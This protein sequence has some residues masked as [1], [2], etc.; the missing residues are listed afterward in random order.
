M[1][2]IWILCFIITAPVFGQLEMSK[3]HFGRNA[4][5]DFV[6]GNPMSFN[7]GQVNSVES[8]SS[9]STAGGFLQFYTDGETVFN[10]NNEVMANGEGLFGNLS[11]T[12]GALIVPFPN[13][14]QRYYIFTGEA[15]QNFDPEEGIVRGINYSV[16]DMSASGGLGAVIEKNTNLLSE[17]S[18]KLSAVLHDNNTDYWLVTNF[19][20]K[21]Y[22]Y[23]VTAS[24]VGT[25]PTITTIGFNADTFEKIRGALTLSP[26][27]NKLAINHT[28]LNPTLSGISELYD[29]N[30]A[31]GEVSN[32]IE[33]GVDDIIY[34]GAAFSPNSEVLY[35]NGKEPLNGNTD[36]GDTSIYQFDLNAGDVL[37]SRYVVTR[38]LASPLVEFAGLMQVALDGKIYHSFGGVQLSVIR[39]P[40]RLRDDSKFQFQAL[41]LGLNSS[42]RSGLPIGVQSFYDNIID[43]DELCF[44]EATEFSLTTSR[45]INS[46]VWDFGDPASGASNSSILFSPTHIFSATGTYTIKATVVFDDGE[47]KQYQMPLSVIGS[48]PLLSGVITKCDVD[49]VDDGRSL[50]NLFE[51]LDGIIVQDE[52]AN[53]AAEVLFFTSLADAQIEINPIEDPAS[54][55]NENDGQVVYVNIY[56]SLDCFKTTDITLFVESS[57]PVEDFDFTICASSI[58]E[59]SAVILIDAVIDAIAFT[60]PDID[61][62]LYSSLE[63]AT[64]EENELVVSILFDFDEEKFVYYRLGEE[65]ECIGVGRVDIELAP[66][67]EGLVNQSFPLCNTVDSIVLEGPSGFLFYDWDTGA[68]TQNLEVFEAGVYNLRVTV[69]LGCSGLV[70]YNVT[71]GPVLEVTVTVND[72]QQINEIIVDAML[73]EGTALFSIDGGG[74][75][76]ESGAFSDL[77]PGTYE[78]VVTDSFG[79]NRIT[80]TVIIRGAPRYFTPNN[81]GFHDT[82]HIFDV[83]DYPGMEIEI[84]DRFGKRIAFL[85]DQTPGWDGTYDGR[86]APTSTYW[87]SVSFEGNVFYGNVALL[88]RDL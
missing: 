73:T 59:V 85:T 48:P 55:Q 21:F 39:K 70:Q 10:R 5:L 86:R 68:T 18:E 15:A 4:G 56:F 33:L 38:Y 76:Q 27:G 22:S 17:G 61:I 57:D 34:Y 47:V 45:I 40:N 28:T 37:G 71:D 87:Y 8:C 43:Y 23:P 50:F 36:T 84:F 78:V 88:G 80:E 58:G 81:D 16:V 29:F 67:I 30:S 35:V 3:W 11:S 51:A 60:Y 20:G 53:P 72:F 46:V 31:T 77:S 66:P 54:Y 63:S 12:N 65:G 69:E 19:K 24:G 49:G 83:E 13:N 62:R 25:T 74:T 32:R 6:T 75:F 26:D 79:C 41:S 2:K 82:W 9:I 7:G 64:L 42:T 44:G 14:T 1:R 52:N